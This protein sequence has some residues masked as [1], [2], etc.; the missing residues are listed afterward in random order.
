MP[1]LTQKTPLHHSIEKGIEDSGMDGK[2]TNINVFVT[3]DKEKFDSPYAFLFI[4]KQNEVIKNLSPSASKM[5]L[6]FCCEMQYGNFVEI[7]Q[8]ELSIFLGLSLR[9]TKNCLNELVACEVLIKYRN[10]NDTR[11]NFYYINPYHS[12][13]GNAKERNKTIKELKS[14]DQLKLEF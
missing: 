11:Q 3:K 5:F 12:W 10:Q 8:K 14:K 1:K 4:G 6:W 9:T 2:G 13:R 7:K